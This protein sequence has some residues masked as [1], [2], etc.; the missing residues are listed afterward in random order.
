M[1]KFK[2]TS[3]TQI[4]HFIKTYNKNNKRPRK[5]YPEVQYTIKDMIMSGVF[6]FSADN[7]PDFETLKV[8]VTERALFRFGGNFTFRPYQL[9]SII[10]II[11]S[12]FT[13]DNFVMEAPTGAGKSI[14]G[15]LVADV[16]NHYF[17]LS[18]YILVSDLGLLDQYVNDIDAYFPEFAIIKGQDNYMCNENK[19]PYP[20]G[21]CK[22]MGVSYANIDDMPCSCNC[23]YINARKKAINAP[24]VLMTYQAWLIHRNYIPSLMMNCSCC[25]SHPFHQREFTICDEAHKLA[26]I[27]Q[28]HF[29]PIINKFDF[30][31]LADIA[32]RSISMIGDSAKIIATTDPL[33]YKKYIDDIFLTDDN[34]VIYQSLSHLYSLISPF[35]DLESQVKDYIGKKNRNKPTKRQVSLMKDCDWAREFSCKI[36]DYVNMIKETGTW[37]IVKTASDDMTVKLNCIDERYLIREHFHLRCGNRLYMSATIGEPMNYV[38]SISSENNRFVSIPSTFDF[39]RSPIYY[40]NEYKL[41][42]NKK[43]ENLPKIIDKI[44]KIVRD[45]PDVKGIIQTGSYQFANELMNN[46]PDDLKS[47]VLMYTDSKD[48]EFQID[49]YK[50]SKNK[51]LIGPSLLEGIDL[52]DDLCRFIIVM[53][54]PYPSLGDKFV[55]R[56]FKLNPQWYMW[57]TVNSLVQ[58]IGRGVRN[59]NDWCET[60]ILDATMDNILLRNRNLIPQHILMRMINVVLNQ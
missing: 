40:D 56:K 52:K 23:S 13:K 54:I 44:I 16:L 39:S 19:L 38:N 31:R 58:G 43:T 15:L 47:R 6:N 10:S 53:K 36:E 26:E 4:E 22:M 24:I 60:Y 5:D 12:F 35:G 1:E 55:E 32:Q 48:K 45:H 7:L 3:K 33:K 46:L 8:L 51:V 11:I 9:D 50:S 17:G 30:N 57:K 2:Y 41:S 20:F 27:I 37:A 49:D 29:S 42:Y 59:E 18:G 28:D 21:V 34:D 14:T 25:G